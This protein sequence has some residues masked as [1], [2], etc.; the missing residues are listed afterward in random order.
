MLLRDCYEI[1]FAIILHVSACSGGHP[2][3]WI[4]TDV[5]QRGEG[6]RL[7]THIKLTMGRIASRLTVIIKTLEQVCTCRCRCGK[8][9]ITVVSRAL[10][11]QASTP[12]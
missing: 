6:D 3:E 4:V 5:S 8:F 12:W 9:I 11:G 10:G 7:Q 1:G 2:A